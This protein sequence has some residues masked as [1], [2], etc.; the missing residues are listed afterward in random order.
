[1][2]N[3]YGCKHVV[4]FLSVF[5]GVLNRV[6]NAELRPKADLMLGADANELCKFPKF[7]LLFDFQ[8]FKV[9]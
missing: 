2:T 9:S 5:E 6:H 4:A 7:M 1:M 3:I 8:C